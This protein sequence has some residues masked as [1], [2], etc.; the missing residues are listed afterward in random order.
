[1]QQAFISY[2][3]MISEL[4]FL[5][6]LQNER[7]RQLVSGGLGRFQSEL[8]GRTSQLANEIGFFQRVF[9][10]AET[11]PH[12]IHSVPCRIWLIW[13]DRLIVKF[14]LRSEGVA[15]QFTDKWKTP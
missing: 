11:P 1:M 3:E 15:G 4:M 8:A 5:T 14:S 9:S 7:F 6:R 13:L 12:S 2:N 10:L